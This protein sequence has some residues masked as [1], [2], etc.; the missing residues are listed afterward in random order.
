MESMDDEMRMGSSNATLAFDALLLKQLNN[1]IIK[2]PNI[3]L[4]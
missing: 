1:F 3:C 2:V 4:F